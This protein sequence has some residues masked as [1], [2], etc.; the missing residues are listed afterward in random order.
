M[1][2]RKVNKNY[3]RFGNAVVPKEVSKQPDIKVPKESLLPL[4][5]GNSFIRIY[6]DASYNIEMNIG[7]T[8][9]IVTKNNEKIY[10]QSYTLSNAKGSTFS[11][12]V[13]IN[14]A[15]EYVYENINPK[16]VVELYT[17]SKMSVNAIME[18]HLKKSKTDYWRLIDNIRSKENVNILYVQAHTNGKGLHTQFNRQA[19]QLCKKHL[20]EIVSEY[21]NS[22]INKNKN[23]NVI[24]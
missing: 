6:T 4:S 12:L 15:I 2:H 1:A 21:K 22:I 16:D 7:V 24:N 8:S 18:G 9:F 13:A 19:D 10:S 3:Y 14:R 20:K 23:T 17:D 5:K 11:E